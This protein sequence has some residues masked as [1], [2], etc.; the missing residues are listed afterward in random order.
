MQRQMLKAHSRNQVREV[1]EG[2]KEQRGIATPLE[3]QPDHQILPET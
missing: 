3:E 2:L 1:A